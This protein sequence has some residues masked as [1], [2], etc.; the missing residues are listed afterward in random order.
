MTDW[1]VKNYLEKIYKVPVAGVRS[2]IMAGPISQ[3]PEGLA[4][5]FDYK[6]VHITLPVGQTFEWPELFPEKKFKEEVSDME[7]TRRELEKGRTRNPSVPN[8]P[9]WFL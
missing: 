8:A 9:G 4:K 6:I 1:D 5:G 7:R 2:K 3:V